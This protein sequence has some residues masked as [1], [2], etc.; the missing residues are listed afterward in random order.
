MWQG[1]IQ[2]A[3]SAGVHYEYVSEGVFVTGGVCVCV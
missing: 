2:A 1:L 3:Q